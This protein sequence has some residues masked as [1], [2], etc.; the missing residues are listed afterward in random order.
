[1]VNIAFIVGKEADTF[2]QKVTSKYAP[3]WLKDGSKPFRDFINDDNTV[4][5][6]VAM[7]AYIHFYHPHDSITLIRGYQSEDITQADLDKQDVIFV[8]FDAIEVFHCGAR[9][10]CPKESRRFERMLAK[11]SAFVYPHPDFHKYIINKPNYY[12]DIKKAGIPVAPFFKVTPNAVLRSPKKF[13]DKI[14]AKGWKGA[15]IKPSYAG[16]SLGIKVLKDVSKTDAKTIKAHFEKLKKKGFPNAVVQEFVP[17]FSK[18]YEIRTYWINERYGYSV[19]TL[20]EAVGSGGGLPITGFD[21]F[22]SEGGSLPNRILEKLK[23]VAQKAIKSILQYPVKHPMVRVDFGC[24]LNVEQCVE[25]YFVNEVET[26]AANLLADHTEYPAVQR[27]AGAAYTFA[28]DVKKLG[29]KNMKGWKPTV[30]PLKKMPCK[31]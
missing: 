14:L 7:A 9:T 4:P 8:I 21:T 12:S 15:I 3:K 11:T 31:N 16:Y 1:M 25:S 10:T 2:P 13:K 27:I 29:R 28:V 6:D 5:S 23:P 18:H 22:V 19:A 17:S 24:C 26:M 30:R 20:T